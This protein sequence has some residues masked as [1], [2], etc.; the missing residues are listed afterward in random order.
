[1]TEE[2]KS[3]YWKRIEDEKINTKLSWLEHRRWN[4]FM[5]TKGYMASTE[6]QMEKYAYKE[7]T[8]HKN[9]PIKLHPM[10]VESSIEPETTIDD[11]DDPNYEELDCLD[12][13]FINMYKMNGKKDNYKQWDKPEEDKPEQDQ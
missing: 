3:N 11:W 4:A 1:M 6:S 9:L 5:R 10:I 8:D 12:T 13:V 7:G 2:E